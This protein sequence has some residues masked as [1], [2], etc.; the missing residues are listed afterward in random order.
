MDLEKQPRPAPAPEGCLVAAVRMP[1]RIV[2]LV[3]VVP[4]RLVWDALV[5]GGRFLCEKALVPL[6]RVIGRALYGVFVWPF[7]M[8]GRYVLL[9]LG[10]GLARLGRVWVV[11]PA[12]W[13]Y[14]RV[15][16]PLGRALGTGLSRLGMALFVWPWVA[17]WRHVLVPMGRGLAW[18]GRQLA[19]GAA[20]VGRALGQLARVLCVVPAVWLYASVLTPV[21]HAIAW[22]VTGIGLCLRWLAMAVFVWPW[23]ALWRYVAVPVA[24]WTYA[25]LLTP[26]G[27][28]VAALVRWLFVLPALAL[29]RWVLVPVGRAV[30]FVAR[31]T[32]DA[33]AVAWRVAGY[34]SL[35]VGRFLGT[36]LRWVFVEPV[37]WV[38]RSV[39]TPVGHAVRDLVWRP[40]AGALREAGRGV[41]Q[42]LAAARASVRQARA[43]VRRAL[44]G[45]DK[46]P[47]P[48]V[49]EVREPEAAQGRT[50]GSSTTSLT[51]TAFTHFTKD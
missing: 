10:R 5:T 21:G 44:F 1:V 11:V 25:Y 41:R 49:R 15:L 26:L 28:G 27:H 24:A 4:V 37:R 32:V 43:D 36:L 13:L 8:L 29:W 30:A 33:L 2:A 47:E 46:A 39:L 6:G 16:A 34:V 12:V 9:P 19:A 42:A 51:N 7:V 18:L 31:E 35:A 38:Y 20:A 22:L 3:V 14:A 17:L 45:S 50:L 40:A 48:Q 23:A